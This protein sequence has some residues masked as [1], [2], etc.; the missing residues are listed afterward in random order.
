KREFR[1]ARSCHSCSLIPDWTRCG[2]TRGLSSYCGGFGCRRSGGSFKSQT[3]SWLK[4][5]SISLRHLFREAQI[6]RFQLV[7]VFPCFAKI[8]QKSTFRNF[9]FCFLGNSS[10]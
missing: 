6:L 5:N 9:Y 8:A 7:V 4:P 10:L 3:S 1:R 2:R